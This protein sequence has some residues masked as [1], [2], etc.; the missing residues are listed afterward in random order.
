ME[1]R[2]TILQP[3]PLTNRI[4]NSAKIIGAKVDKVAKI[5]LL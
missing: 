4:S 3:N 2:I 5:F 1:R